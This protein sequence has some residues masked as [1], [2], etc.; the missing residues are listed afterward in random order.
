MVNLV[1][2]AD[3]V[4]QIRRADDSAWPAGAEVRLELLHRDGTTTDWVADLVNQTAVWNVDKA[5]VNTAIAKRIRSTRL[6]YKQGDFDSLKD[7]IVRVH[8]R[9]T[10]PLPATFAIPN[11]LSVQR[12][13]TTLTAIVHGWRT[14][15]ND[16][17]AQLEAE[18]EVEQLTLEDIFLELHR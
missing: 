5:Q 15:M 14:E 11:A 9:A 10:R 1:E 17:L 6:W 12:N 7:S 13:G 3:F 2:D 18:I 8:A 16:A 4:H